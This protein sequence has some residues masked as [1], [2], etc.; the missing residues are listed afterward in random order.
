MNNVERVYELFLSLNFF[1]VRRVFSNDAQPALG[2]GRPF[3][4]TN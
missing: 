3:K 2:Q 1:A 4:T